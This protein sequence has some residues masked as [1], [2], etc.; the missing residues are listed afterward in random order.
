LWEI[1][2]EAADEKH[3]TQGKNKLHHASKAAGHTQE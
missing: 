2:T 1:F 3:N